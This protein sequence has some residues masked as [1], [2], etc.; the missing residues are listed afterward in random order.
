LYIYS[1]K[2]TGI[3]YQGLKNYSDFNTEDFLGDERFRNWMISGGKEDALFWED[4]T[5][6][7]P[8]KLNDLRLAR[9][10]FS[11]LHHL[12]L[13]AETDVKAKIW[14]NLESLV[15]ADYG[16]D[17]RI[18]TLYRRWWMIA[19]ALLLAGGL[20]WMLRLTFT[21]IPLEYKGQVSLSETSLQET[22][23]NTKTEQIVFLKDGS[24]VKL[25]SGSKVS[26]SDFTE[27]QRA[28]FLDGEGFFEVTKDVT[29]PFMVYA[30]NIVVEVVGT[31][32]SVVSG[33]GKIKSNV[34]VNSGKVKVFST[35]KMNEP[36]KEDQ[37]IYLTPNQQVVFDANANIF[38]KGLVA[39][40]VQVARTGAAQEFYFT[41]TSVNDILSELE[42]A[43]GVKVRFN[44]TDLESCKVTAPLGDLPLFRKLDIICQ[45]IGATYEV[46]G[47]EIVIS[48]GDCNL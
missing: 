1:A 27:N 29:R 6:Q 30:G 10:L 13:E 8:E 7:Y 9:N 34:S 20:G 25:K 14:N 36:D 31:S 26:Y 41:N 43:Y 44:N 39:E 2:G 35:K 4:F 47:T 17:G 33:T 48:G 42:M 45:T 37:A 40:P 12:Q 5:S 23:N 15:D 21:G 19:A 46:F 22:V 24:T 11:S 16:R 3:N 32:F 28:V 18:R 38:V